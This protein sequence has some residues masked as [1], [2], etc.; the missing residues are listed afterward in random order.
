MVDQTK[1]DPMMRGL[2]LYE[3]Q[4]SYAL[5]GESRQYRPN[6]TAHVVTTT[7][8]RA[9][10]VAQSQIVEDQTDFVVHQIIRRGANVLVDMIV[11]TTPS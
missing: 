7:I 6:R 2:N 4:Y 11:E 10:V 9:I 5:V 1:G 8:E 3:V